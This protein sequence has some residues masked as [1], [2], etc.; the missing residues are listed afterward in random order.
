MLSCIIKR[1]DLEQYYFEYAISHVKKKEYLLYVSSR[2]P[3]MKGGG[4]L[5]IDKNERLST[6]T[7]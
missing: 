5:S 1:N 2:L 4:M 7:K 6:K 3:I